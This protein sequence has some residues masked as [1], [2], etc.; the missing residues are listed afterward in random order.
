MFFPVSFKDEARLHIRNKF[1]IF[2]C[3]KF[4][5]FCNK[6]VIFCNKFVTFDAWDIAKKYHKKRVKKLQI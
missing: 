5:T 1:G 3:N 2:I 4:V 6:F